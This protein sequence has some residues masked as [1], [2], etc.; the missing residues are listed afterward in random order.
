MLGSKPDLAY[1]PSH[2]HFRSGSRWITPSN[3]YQPA[4]AIDRMP[5]FQV[6]QVLL[7]VSCSRIDRC[8]CFDCDQRSIF[9]SE[10]GIW[11]TLDWLIIWIPPEW[12]ETARER[13]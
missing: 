2:L 8:R 5:G 12:N 7:P 1:P 3:P 13:R 10:I 4:K 9:H 6:N 11:P